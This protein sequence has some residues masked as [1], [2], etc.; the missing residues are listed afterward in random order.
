MKFT[1]IMTTFND[2]DMIRQSVASI[3]NQSFEDF[4]LIIVD[5]GSAQPTKDILAEFDDPRIRVLPQANDGLSSARNRGLRHAKGDYI[6]FLDADDTRSPWSFAEAAE[7]INRTGADLVVTRGSFCGERTTLAPF[8]D[9]G[10]FAQMEAEI[11]ETGPLPLDRRKAWAATME[12]QSA[13]KFVAREVI[14]RGKLVFPNDH[15]FED[16]F[17]HTMVV[18]WATSIE[19]LDSRHFTYFQRQLRPQLTA[20]KGTVR[21]DIIGTA[22]VTLQVFEQHP[23]FNNPAMRGALTISALR[24]L[25]WCE[26]SIAAYH[27]FAYRTALRAMLRNLDPKYLTLDKKTPDPRNEGEALC[28]FAKDVV[29]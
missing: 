3:L 23:E 9:E 7:V 21:F 2:G 10:H 22:G 24:L 12:P 26:G 1:C 14:E 5:D 6:C 25:Q 20:A 16:L 15:F 17:F 13:N 11:G 4:E 8:H 19:F 27:R 18:A 28:R 29:A